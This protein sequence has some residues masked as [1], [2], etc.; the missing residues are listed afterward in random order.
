M[1]EVDKLDFSYGD[2]EVLRDVSVHVN[3]GELVVLFGPNGCGKSTLLKTIGGF[4]RCVSGCIK[5]DGRE[6]TKLPSQKIVAMGIVYISQWR[7]LFPDMT[8]EENLKLGAYNTNARAKEAENFDYVFQLFPKLKQWRNRLASTLSGGEAR[9]LAIGRGLM[10]NGKF[11][12]ID[13]PSAGLAPNLRAE[14]FGKIEEINES[15]ISVFLV[16]QNFVEA[17]ELADR[18]YLIEDGGIVL[19]GGREEVL[20]NKHV[21]EA[22]LGI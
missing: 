14:M 17:S 11:L 6:I 16:E 18:M 10:S 20:S 9:M 12:A 5:F 1:L 2:F 21:K 15:G 8:V 13:E 3:D 4:L 22:F 19:E 7:N